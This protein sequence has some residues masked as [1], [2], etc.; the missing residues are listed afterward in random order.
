MSEI[1]GG[2]YANENDLIDEALR[3]DKLNELDVTKFSRGAR[4]LIKAY[5]DESTFTPPVGEFVTNTIP[6][7][8]EETE[9][10]SGNVDETEGI[11]KGKESGE[12]QSKEEVPLTLPGL[13]EL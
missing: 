3:N 12:T 2:P 7:P 10:E 11:E 8:S 5:K 1:Y 6:H 13:D 4:A 9:E